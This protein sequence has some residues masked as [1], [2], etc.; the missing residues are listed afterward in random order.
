MQMTNNA[1]R[2]NEVR[3][4]FHIAILRP[5]PLNVDLI[6]LKNLK[7]ARLVFI[8]TSR[9]CHCLFSRIHIKIST[10]KDQ[11]LIGLSGPT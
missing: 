4:I 7:S 5:Q 8:R 1:I 11:V 3:L 2:L 10:K 9:V 6:F